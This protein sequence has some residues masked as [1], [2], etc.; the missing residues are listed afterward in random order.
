M[1]RKKLLTLLNREF[2][3]THWYPI[4][5]GGHRGIGLPLNGSDE[6]ICIHVAN[7]IL[8]AES[9]ESQ[10]GGACG[11]IGD[12]RR[13]PLITQTL[14]NVGCVLALLAFAVAVMHTVNKWYVHDNHR[15]LP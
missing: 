5:A 11:W 13:I 9:F 7:N 6:I 15:E 12:S 2:K 14:L 4:Q 8:Q 3:I 1:L 10:E